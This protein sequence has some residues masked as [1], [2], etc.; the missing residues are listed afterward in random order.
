MARTDLVAGIFVATTIG[1]LMRRVLAGFVWFI[2]FQSTLLGVGGAIF[3]AR[4]GADARG[5]AGGYEVG[6]A[7]GRAF[8]QELGG[9]VFLTALAVAVVGTW[10]GTLPGTRK[11]VAT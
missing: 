9:L 6:Q 4:A 8:G 3:G 2:V 1:G 11:A 5:F 7:A 10:R